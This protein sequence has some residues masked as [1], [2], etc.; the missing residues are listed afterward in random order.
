[1]PHDENFQQYL[2]NTAADMLLEI[3]GVPPSETAVMTVLRAAEIELPEPTVQRC[4]TL[5]EAEL[6]RRIDDPF[7]T[8]DALVLTLRKLVSETWDLGRA[9]ALA[10]LEKFHPKIARLSEDLSDL[11]ERLQSLFDRLQEVIGYEHDGWNA[12]C[13]HERILE[14]L[15]PL[16]TLLTKID[17]E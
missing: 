10:D 13:S 14:L 8:A 7:Y 17:Q 15:T 4:L 6:D 1:M 11:D 2:V 9:S 16:E 12:L 3:L 5:W